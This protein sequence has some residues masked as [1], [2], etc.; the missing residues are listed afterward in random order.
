MGKRILLF[1]VASLLM[2]CG[3]DK[4]T[5]LTLTP[6][7]TEIKGPLKGCYEVVQQDYM[8]QQQNSWSSLINVELKRTNQE[9]PFDPQTASGFDGYAETLVGFGIELIDEDGEVVEVIDANATGLSGPYSSDDIEAAINLTPGET[10]IVR[11]SVDMENEPV[12]FRIT[13]AISKGNSSSDHSSSAITE[14]S[15]TEQPSNDWDKVLDKYEQ[16]VD[17]YIAI[18]KK[19]MNGDLSASMEYL[20]LLDDAEE[21]GDELDSASDEMSPEQISRYTRITKKLSNIATES[22]GF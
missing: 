22:V 16:Y 20:D 12:S 14:P 13:S 10:G 17:Q 15:T 9:L 8:I 7:T 6:E 2:S 4:K 3:G 5:E 11:W 19:A 1:A 21:L 18:S